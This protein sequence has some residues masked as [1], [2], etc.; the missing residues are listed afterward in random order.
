MILYIEFLAFQII[1]LFTGLVLAGVYSVCSHFFSVLLFTHLWAF[2]SIIMIVL[3]SSHFVYTIS[4]SYLHVCDTHIAPFWPY[5]S[6]VFF[7][8]FLFVTLFLACQKKSCLCITLSRVYIKPAIWSLAS[9]WVK[10]SPD[11]AIRSQYLFY[12]EFYI[13]Y[14]TLFFSLLFRLFS[15]FFSKLYIL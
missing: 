10:S 13:I 7:V 2:R 3:C 9:E 12:Y 8:F 5:I 14:K 15:F 1:W 11:L 4:M 6:Q